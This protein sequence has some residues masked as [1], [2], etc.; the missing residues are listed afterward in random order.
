VAVAPRPASWQY[1][2]DERFLIAP[3][4]WTH[5]EAVAQ[6]V[7]I[8]GERKRNGFDLARAVSNNQAVLTFEHY[9][10]Q[11]NTPLSVASVTISRL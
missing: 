10:S 1:V 3:E 5:P 9:L 2:I 8:P 6:D 7:S 4:G 11:T